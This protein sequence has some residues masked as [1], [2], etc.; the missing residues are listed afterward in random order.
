MDRRGPHAIVRSVD[1]EASERG[2]RGGAMSRAR[3]LALPLVMAAAALPASPAPADE[4][5]PPWAAR[6]LAGYPGL[7]TEITA[8]E[9]VLRDG[10]RFPI[11]PSPPRPASGDDPSA[12]NIA[13]MFAQAYPAGSAAPPAAGADPGRARFAPFFDHIYGDCRQGEV[14][15]RLRAVAWMPVL[16]HQTVMATTANRVADRLD[17]VVRDLAALPPDVTRQL[18]PSAGTYNCRAIAGTAQRSMHSYGVAIDIAVRASDYW[19][20]AGGESA[21]WRNRIDPR[22]VAAFEKHGF[23]WGG[24]WSHFDTMHFEYRPEF[25]DLR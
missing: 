5:P 1:D 14:A 3:S 19:R 6:L 13:D 20:W 24:R 18:V 21:R 17:A 12:R 4:A 10:T 23:I 8:R 16:G 7:V 9:V 25:F 22:I 11:A 15:S 2:G